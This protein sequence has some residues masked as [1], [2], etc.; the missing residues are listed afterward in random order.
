MKLKKAIKEMAAYL[1]DKD[2]CYIIIAAL[3]TS[4]LIIAGGMFVEGERR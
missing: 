3:G 1:L 4:M 2:M